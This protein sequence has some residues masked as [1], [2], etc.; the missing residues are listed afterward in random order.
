MSG[1]LAMPAEKSMGCA[2][3]PDFTNI[4]RVLVIPR[5]AIETLAAMRHFSQKPG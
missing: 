5:T 2:I 3:A 1:V 4:P